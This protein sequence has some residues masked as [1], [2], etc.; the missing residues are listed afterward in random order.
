MAHIKYFLDDY[1]KNKNNFQDFT[2]EQFKAYDK[3]FDDKLE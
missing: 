2:L 3:Y 1:E